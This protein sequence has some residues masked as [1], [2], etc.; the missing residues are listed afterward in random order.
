MAGGESKWKWNDLESMKENALPTENKAK[1][2]REALSNSGAMAKLQSTFGNL[3]EQLQH[4]AK[5]DMNAEKQP[6]VTANTAAPL[7]KPVALA[8]SMVLLPPSMHMPAAPQASAAQHAVSSLG[9]GPTVTLLQ[10]APSL[11]HDPILGVGA[12]LHPHVSGK[13][14]SLDG[15]G[16]LFDFSSR[17]GSSQVIRHAVEVF[18]DPELLIMC[19][20]GLNKQLTRT[21]DGATE[22]SRIQELAGEGGGGDIGGSLIMCRLSNLGSRSV[23]LSCKLYCLT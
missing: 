18:E 11:G 16:P 17:N 22:A 15:G 2:A 13:L 6:P 3:Q 10:Q 19:D 8:N 4:L 21:R 9:G 7:S 5:R 23:I 1:I 20:E 12:S 14:S